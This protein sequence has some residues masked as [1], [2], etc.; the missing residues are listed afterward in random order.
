MPF[1]KNLL[2]LLRRGHLYAGL[3]LAPWVFLYGVT[4]FLFSHPAVFPD[5]EMIPIKARETRGTEIASLPKAAEI[6]DEVVELINA[7]GSTTYELVNREAIVFGRGGFVT[8]VTGPEGKSYSVVLHSNGAGM[9]RG[10]PPPPPGTQPAGPQP[11]R[12]A[13]R[14]TT[15]KQ[16]TAGQ[17]RRS[18]SRGEH[19]AGGDLR[20]QPEQAPFAVDQ[21][22]MLQQSPVDAVKAGL[23]V[24][25]KKMNLEHLEVTD[26]QLNPITFSMRG[27]DRY[28]SVTYN[29]TTGSVT[30]RELPGGIRQSTISLRLF[31]LRLHM[32][33][34]YPADEMNMRWVWVL[35]AD[36]TALI[37]IFWG[38]SGIV[39]WWQIKR[40]RLWGGICLGLS[41]AAASYIG[42]GMHEL[43]RA[44][45]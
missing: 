36:T 6:A 16:E 32:V 40:T 37:M 26:V 8:N 7:R 11:S 12:G 19:S 20:E 38:V 10:A 35:V 4:G 14:M 42:I 25:L 45:R 27:D 31:L 23:P 34:G 41:V 1:V 21:G 18:R 3:L 2:H 39:M 28:W 29:P 24:V 15:D 9:I 33:H 13:S 44:G 22:L 5:N 17:E 30:G 43:M